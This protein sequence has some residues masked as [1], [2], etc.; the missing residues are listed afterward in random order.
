MIQRYKTWLTGLFKAQVAGLLD[1]RIGPLHRKLDQLSVA[2]P[3]RL[4]HLIDQAL[5]A[6]LGPMNQTLDRLEHEAHEPLRHKVNAALDDRLTA[7]HQKLDALEA[8]SHGGRATYLGDNRVL[9]KVVVDGSNLAFIVEADDK[10]FSPWL[11]ITGGYDTDLTSFFVRALRPDSHC[12]DVGANFGYFTCL[13]GR[14]A[15]QGRVIGIEPDQAVF[16][17]ARDNVA[18]NGLNG[19][20]EMVHAAASDTSAE[21]TL[22]RR[23]TRSGNTSIVAYGR[24][25]TDPLG[26]APS[27]PFIVRGVPID[28]LTGSM[29]GRVDLM[30]VDVEGAEPLVFA[31]A[32]QTIA[33]NP[34][35][36]VVMEWSP[37]QIRDAGF[38]LGHFV[39]D[40]EGHGLKPFDMQPDGI[41]PISYA[42]L[43]NMPYQPGVVLKK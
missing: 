38:D 33:D 2:D 19:V 28:S 17:L 43:L 4:R 29:G 14:R 26:E 40:L 24:E 12:I 7:V 31:G 5:D 42:E 1:E 41:S 13:M 30:K 9:V 20:A 21:L 34:Q 32:R 25:F 11:I 8:N 10:L 39:A 27:V 3:D 37:G 23:L 16:E 36:Q 6:R 15:P 35:L 18:I 22:H